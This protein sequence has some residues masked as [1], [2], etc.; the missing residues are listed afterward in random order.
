MDERHIGWCAHK[1]LKSMTI[2]I[3][4]EG[5]ADVAIVRA[6]MKA[7][8]GVDTSEMRA[9]RPSECTDETDNVA[10]QFSNWEMVMQSASD[11]ELLAGFFDV[12]DDEALLILHVDTA[13]RG[14]ANYNVLEPQR[15]GRVD[16]KEYSTNLRANVRNKLESL[17]PAEYRDRVAYAIAIEETDA[18]LIPLYE[19]QHKHDSA[20]HV[21]P[22]EDLR[23]LIS[24][25]KKKQR[26]IDTEHKN[27]NYINLGKD[28]T[29]KLKI[30]RTQNESLNLFCVEVESR[31]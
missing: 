29:S 1:L 13:E 30:A 22:K 23:A 5:H 21:R 7:L 10:M 14:E 19:S 24:K 28:I 16:W 20:S 15:S 2:G 8:T 17:V 3:I 12:F 27:L 31:L 11:E 4:A 26:Y 9:I 18:W 6:V 25:Q